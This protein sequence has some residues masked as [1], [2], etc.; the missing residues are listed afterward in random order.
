[1]ELLIVDRTKHAVNSVTNSR[2]TVAYALWLSGIAV[3]DI[4][5]LSESGINGIIVSARNDAIVVRIEVVIACL[6][7]TFK[8]TCGID[9]GYSVLHVFPTWAVDCPRGIQIRKIIP[10]DV[11]CKI[12]IKVVEDVVQSF[13]G[14]A[15]VIK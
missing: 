13:T 3:L 9:A 5:T 15:A 4:L 8:T 10:T 11:D 2:I 7:S 1:M 12:F 14:F 6:E